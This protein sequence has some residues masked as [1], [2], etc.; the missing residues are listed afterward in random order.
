MMLHKKSI[1][2]LQGSVP[3]MLTHDASHAYMML[4]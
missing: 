3:M 2:Q 1:I 4:T